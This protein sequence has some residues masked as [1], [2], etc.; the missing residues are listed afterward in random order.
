MVMAEKHVSSISS[1]NSTQEWLLDP[2]AY[3]DDYLIV[4]HF[5]FAAIGI[6][7][8]VCVVGIFLGFRRLRSQRH[9]SWLGVGF[10]N[11]FLLVSH[12]LEALAAYSSSPIALQL[13]SCFLDLAFPCLLL[14]YFLSLLERHFCLKHSTWHKAKVSMGWIVTCQ[15]GSFL[16]LCLALK[17]RHLL[18]A[19][20]F[21]WQMSPSDINVASSFIVAGFFMCIVAQ[22]AVWTTSNQA[23]FTFVIDTGTELRQINEPS[24]EK[25]VTTVEDEREATCEKVSS[26]FVHI[27]EK[28]ISRLDL[29]A[30][31]SLT[32]SFVTL[33][34]GTIP[35]L[36]TLIFMAACIQAT[37]PGVRPDCIHLV[38]TVYYLREFILAH[39]AIL[40]PIIVV[41]RSR[42]VRSAL[43]D[44][45]FRISLA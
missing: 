30:A 28:R 31:H 45:G 24:K 34:I 43:R 38:V 15:V 11:I 33:M 3:L 40:S 7:L 21:Q 39:S 25:S 37:A 10:S 42:E 27:G 17:G 9:F 14:N 35:A 13:C 4:S 32:I 20:P 1:D 2:G 41:S 8:N 5:T 36:V 26:P 19:F 23:R 22:A 44:R 6:P 16:I 18:E 12:L 29:E